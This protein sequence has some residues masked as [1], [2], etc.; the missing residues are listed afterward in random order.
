LRFDDWVSGETSRFAARLSA[1][2]LRAILCGRRSE[3]A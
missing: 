2:L 3:R 1:I